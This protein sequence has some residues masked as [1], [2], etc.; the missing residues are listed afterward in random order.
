MTGASA[1]EPSP[2][3]DDVEDGEADR[4]ARE[5]REARDAGR[6][7]PY[8]REEFERVASREPHLRMVDPWRCAYNLAAP[9][10]AKSGW[11]TDGS[12][13]PYRQCKMRLAD[14][15]KSRY[16][17]EHSIELG[18]AYYSPEEG[19]AI[20]QAEST[21][22]LL[23]LVPKAIGTLEDVMNDEDAPEGVRVKAAES[24]LDRTGY[25]KGL[26]IN[27]NAKVEIEDPLVTLRERLDGLRD[28]QME[29]A[30]RMAAE[31]AAEERGIE[32]GSIVEGEVI[33]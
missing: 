24:V 26:E 11:S 18:V 32:D 14:P 17:Y 25:G 27:L 3:D 12:R 1:F 9:G 29:A 21:S 13:Y 2:F 28:A 10:G 7:L 15:T 23:R 16:C 4:A 33:E 30:A 6:F 5:A 22:N 20:V 8:T 31:A 19:A